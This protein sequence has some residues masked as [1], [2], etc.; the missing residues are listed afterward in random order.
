MTI[1]TDTFHGFPRCFQAIAGIVPRFRPW[2][3]RVLPNSLFA[4]SIIQRYLQETRS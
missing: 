3:F 4:N 2:L 1:L